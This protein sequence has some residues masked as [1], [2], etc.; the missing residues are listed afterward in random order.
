[1]VD[2]SNGLG[3]K[4]FFDWSQIGLAMGRQTT[5]FYL[6]HF[7]SLIKLK[8]KI[9]GYSNEICHDLRAPTK[10]LSVYTYKIIYPYFS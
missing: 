8:I 6:N 9:I 10:M 7:M 2:Y 4:T 3:H 5:N 1:M